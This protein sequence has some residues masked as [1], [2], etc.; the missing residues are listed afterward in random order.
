MTSTN[1]LDDAIGTEERTLPGRRIRWTDTTGDVQEL[2][3]TNRELV[4]WDKTAPRHKWGHATE[5]PFLARSFLAWAAARR[6][7]L[8]TLT[9]DQWNG[10]EYVIEDI[11]D[12]DGE[13]DGD[14]ARPTPRAAGA[15]S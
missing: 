6:D 8:T 15:D 9:F 5:V 14:D 2:R 13:E 3:V 11:E 10:E 1:D 7:G 4:A 12:E